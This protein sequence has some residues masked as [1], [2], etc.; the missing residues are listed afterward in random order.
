[1]PFNQTL[2]NLTADTKCY[3]INLELSFKASLAVKTISD[4]VDLK[5]S[6]NTFLLH[7]LLRRKYFYKPVWTFSNVSI[8][9]NSCAI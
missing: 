8:K 5:L 1:M 6:R 4:R 2:A 3:M 7:S 9:A